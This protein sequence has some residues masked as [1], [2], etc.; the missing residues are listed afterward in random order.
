[1]R[2]QVLTAGFNSWQV[3]RR[4]DGGPWTTVWVT[5]TR[6]SMKLELAAGHTY[7]FRTAGLDNAGN[8]GSWSTVST[9]IKPAVGSI[10][11]PRR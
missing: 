11:T 4:T 8:W 2:L 5:T 7:E 9:T 1:V 3:Q 6:S 10:S